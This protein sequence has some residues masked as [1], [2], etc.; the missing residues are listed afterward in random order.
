M[1]E[2]LVPVQITGL[3]S[4]K[5]ALIDAFIHEGELRERERIT[6]ML[7]TDSPLWDD[8]RGTQA[9]LLAMINEDDA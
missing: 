5:V 9:A 7:D 2:K 3:D 1:S 8:P 6:G 4:V